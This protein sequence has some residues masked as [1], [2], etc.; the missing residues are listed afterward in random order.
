[1]NAELVYRVLLWCA[2]AAEILGLIAVGVFL[3]KSMHGPNGGGGVGAF[4]LLFPALALCACAVT[5]LATNSIEVRTVCLAFMAMPILLVGGGEAR[6]WAEKRWLAP[7][8]EPMPEPDRFPTPETKA[9]GIAIYSSDA[10]RVKQILP[11]VKNLDQPLADNTTLLSYAV[12]YVYAPIPARLEIVR[13]LLKAGADPNPPGIPIVEIALRKD[14]D[15]LLRVLLEAGANPNT[16]DDEGHPAWW[17]TLHAGY[18][19]MER[20][21]MLLDHGADVKFRAEQQ[22]P[23]SLA[24]SAGKWAHAVLLIERGADWKHEKLGTGELASE[25]VLQEYKNTESLRNEIPE[26]LRKL[27][28][29]YEGAR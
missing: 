18:W 20:F 27:K 2:F 29:M 17:G 4:L 5:F 9:L 21:Q 14:N 7:R 25:K 12:D 16:L 1:M 13:L 24:V 26:D 6:S 28:Q 11:T 19:Y 22:G 15:D 3:E 23:V 8:Y 10:E